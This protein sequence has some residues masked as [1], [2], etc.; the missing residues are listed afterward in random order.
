MKNYSNT[1]AVPNFGYVY[2]VACLMEVRENNK[3]NDGNHKNG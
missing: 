3:G 2:I 1:A